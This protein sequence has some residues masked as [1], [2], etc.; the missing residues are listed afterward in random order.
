[1]QAIALIDM[2]ILGD[3]YQTSGQ[4]CI[5]LHVCNTTYQGLSVVFEDN[6]FHKQMLSLTRRHVS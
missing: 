4:S 3:M 6:A 5:F 2:V 1:M